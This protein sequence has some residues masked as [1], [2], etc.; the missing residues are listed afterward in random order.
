MI[1]TPRQPEDRTRYHPAPG[2]LRY[3]D[4]TC[5]F[6][7]DDKVIITY[8]MVGLGDPDDL[9]QQFGMEIEEVAQRWGFSRHP[10]HGSAE[11][12]R[13]EWWSGAHRVRVFSTDWFY[14]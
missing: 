8:C 14:Q 9:E 7:D 1:G 10:R 4:A 5:T 2:P 6:F 12:P 3:N 11:I 13:S